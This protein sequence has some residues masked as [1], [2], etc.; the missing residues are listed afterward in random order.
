[1]QIHQPGKQTELVLNAAFVRTI[2]FH[3]W[4][5]LKQEQ[6]PNP[7]ALLN[8]WQADIQQLVRDVRHVFSVGRSTT[9]CTQ[10]LEAVYCRIAFTDPNTLVLTTAFQSSDQGFTALPDWEN[11][12]P[13]AL[14]KLMLSARKVRR[15]TAGLPPDSAQD[16]ASSYAPAWQMSSPA[17]EPVGM[18]TYT[19]LLQSMLVLWKLAW[20]SGC[21]SRAVQTPDGMTA[22]T[23]LFETIGGLCD[24]LKAYDESAA[25]GP[26]LPPQAEADAKAGTAEAEAEG[27]KQMSLMLVL[28]VLRTMPMMVGQW[29]T[30]TDVCC[31]IM[32]ALMMRSQPSTYQ[33]VAKIIID[34]GSVPKPYNI[35]VYAVR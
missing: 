32:S 5:T 16:Q 14:D 17:A 22:V 21:V 1:M 20:I 2:A 29:T 24:Q 33:A 10:A 15:Q 13:Y 3:M 4:H 8:I 35:A 9:E 11:L 34:K 30:E 6:H 23:T 12:L 31:K 26:N 7:A 28:L 27:N 18:Q 19:Q 25:K